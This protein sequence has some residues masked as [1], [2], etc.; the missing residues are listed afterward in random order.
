MQARILSG[1]HYFRPSIALAASFILLIGLFL[2]TQAQAATLGEKQKHFDALYEQ[3]LADP[4]NVDVTLEYANLAVEIGDYE[5][6]IAPLERLLISN[7]GA[8]KIRLE[9]GMMYYLL[10]SY[11]VARGYFSEITQDKKAA[12]DLVRQ[13]NAY[14]KR[15]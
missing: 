1:I 8:H 3:L 2:A 15:L 13:A 6:A 4:A 11:D 12:P 7:P 5:A 14:L 10:G 9:L